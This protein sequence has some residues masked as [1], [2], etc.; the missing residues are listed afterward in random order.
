MIYF[1]SR[2][3]QNAGRLQVNGGFH[4]EKKR[5]TRSMSDK[6]IFGVC[7]GLAKYFDTDPTII[8]IIWAVM[9]LVYGAGLLVY[10]IAALIMP[11][12]E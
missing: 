5:L 10:L 1:I 3:R 9:V 8:R 4:M 12:G 6:K 2:Q 7:G 11:V